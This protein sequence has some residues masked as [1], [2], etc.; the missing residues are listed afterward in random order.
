M[1]VQNT[2]RTDDPAAEI[3]ATSGLVT[4]LGA[5]VAAV[6]AVVSLG[7]GSVAMAGILGLLAVASFAAS[8]VCFA[9]DSN[10]SEETPLPFPSWLRAEPETAAES[11]ALAG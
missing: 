7:D 5:V 1:A 3:L 4:M 10:R 9:V 6:I 8:M 2:R 11:P